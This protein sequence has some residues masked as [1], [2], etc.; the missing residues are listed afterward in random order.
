MSIAYTHDDNGYYVGQTTCQPNPRKVGEFLLPANSTSVDPGSIPQDK[1]AKWDG[2]AWVQEN[3]PAP[4]APTQEELEAQLTYNE[5]Y[6]AL[7]EISGETVVDRLQA[8]IDSETETAAWAI[9]RGQRTGLINEVEWMKAR[10]DDE[11]ALSMATTLTGAEHT[12]L[13]QYIQDLRDITNGITDPVVWLA[14]P[15]WTTKPT[16]V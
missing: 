1:L 9:L 11:T 3:V 2:S 6:V 13:I 14:T 10:H 7:K 5:Y 16:F 15:T 12:E 4:A 8:T